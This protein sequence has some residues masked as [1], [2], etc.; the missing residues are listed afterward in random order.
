MEPVKYD[1]LNSKK[2]RIVRED[3]VRDQDG[4]CHYCKAPLDGPPAEEVAKKT[5]HKKLYP[6]GFFRW[7]VHLHHSHDTGMTIGAVHCYCNA[8]LWEYENE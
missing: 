8:V 6:Q 2:K 7:P 3:Y 4:K 1:N 5:I